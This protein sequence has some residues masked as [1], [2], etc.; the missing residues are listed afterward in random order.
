MRATNVIQNFLL[1]TL[2][3][4]KNQGEINCNYIFCLNQ[5]IKNIISACHKHN[6]Y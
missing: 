2:K 4:K 6:S 3:K 5:Y 1:A